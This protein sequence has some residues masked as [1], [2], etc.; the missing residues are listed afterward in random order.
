MGI[1][2]A[3]A[4]LIGLAIASARPEDM[5]TARAD[6]KRIEPFF[7]VVAIVL[8]GCLLIDPLLRWMGMLR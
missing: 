6:I 2:I 8:W 1:L 4:V 7:L 3:V 5:P